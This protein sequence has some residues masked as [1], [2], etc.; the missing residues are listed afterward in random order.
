MKRTNQ[1]RDAQLEEAK[2]LLDMGLKRA[3]VAATLQRDYALSRATAY[4]D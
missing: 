2:R 3:D 4:R 1:E